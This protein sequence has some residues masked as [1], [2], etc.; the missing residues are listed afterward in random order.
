ML[1]D[2]KSMKGPSQ[3]QSNLLGVAY[4]EK[5]HKRCGAGVAPASWL[6]AS[7]QGSFSRAV[8]SQNPEESRSKEAFYFFFHFFMIFISVLQLV[9][10]VLS[11]YMYR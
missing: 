4:W 3:L 9:F 2:E 10:S 6:K 11:I 1:E 8:G 5:A 7:L